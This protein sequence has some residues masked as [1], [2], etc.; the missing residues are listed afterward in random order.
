MTD[1]K[2]RTVLI[3]Q[4][5]SLRTAVDAMLGEVS[6]NEQVQRM[7]VAVA[8][9]NHDLLVT[10]GIEKRIAGVLQILGE[11]CGCDLVSLLRREQRGGGQE[12]LFHVYARWSGMS[13]PPMQQPR[14]LQ[15]VGAQHWAERL[16]RGETI[17]ARAEDQPPP[18]QEFLQSVN[19][20][21]VLMVPVPGEDS[22]WGILAFNASDAE[23]TWSAAEEAILST[24]AS[25]IGGA[26]A[27][28]RA[29]QRELELQ[30]ELLETKNG[31]SLAKL[32]GGIAHDFNNILQAMIGHLELLD[33][34]VSLGT[35]AKGNVAALMSAAG[36]ATELVEKLRGYAGRS[37]GAQNELDVNDVLRDIVSFARSMLPEKVTLTLEETAD[38][39]PIRGDATQ[40]SRVFTNLIVNAAEAMEPGTGRIVLRPDR[41]RPGSTDGGRIPGR[42]Y[43]RVAVIDNGP[44]IDEET[45]A[46][47]FQPF[48]ST[49]GEGRGL[50]LAA[51]LGIVMSHGGT[52]EVESALG[53][54]TTFNVLLPAA[55]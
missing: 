34:E 13:A 45:R 54:G 22:Y 28:K 16:E 36:R 20:A 30:R 32:A 9:A 35:A 6:A 41:F 21:S 42:T 31:E 53:K 26:L 4:L 19:V 40:L 24:M 33:R 47:I 29:S 50:G 23:R 12:D 25:G 48:F 39:P 5:S 2:E 38:L 27:R 44:G 17:R 7:L 1:S 52:I 15:E 46:H 10:H 49:K 55:G 11:A 51:V 14:T 3:T 43:V 8:E 37:P 18:L